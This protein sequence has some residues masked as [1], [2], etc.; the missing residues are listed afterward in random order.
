MDVLVLADAYPYPLQNGHALRLYHYIR[1]LQERH[2]FDLACTADTPVPP[3]L[4]ALF[5]RITVFPKPP[6]PAVSSWRRMRQAFSA[7]SLLRPSPEMGCMIAD[8]MKRPSYDLIW[9]AGDATLM[10]IPARRPIPLLGDLVDDGVLTVCRE[11]TR[12]RTLMGRLAKLRRA[13]LVAA[14]ER[15][16]YGKVDSCL[17]VSEIDERWFRR[18]CP[19]TPTRV[20]HNGVDAQF[21]RPMPGPEAPCSLVFEGNLAFK[22]NHDAVLYFCREILPLI[23]AKVPEATLTVVGKDPDAEI[24]DMAGQCITVTGYVDDIRPYLA[25]SA[26]F[27]CPMRKGAGIKNKILQAWAMG[28]ATVATPASTGGLDAQEGTN[29][30]IRDGTASFA[31][32]VV[33]L[34]RDPW[35]RRSLG[36][37]ARETILKHYTWEQKAGELD[38]LMQSLVTR[39]GARISYSRPRTDSSA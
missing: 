25:R 3:E 28:K 33:A 17:L 35:R 32:A 20:I 5:R 24:L 36:R 6:H 13:A 18:I 2:N 12:E 1:R 39:G 23:R 38:A 22:P 37:A 21:F 31:S 34:L 7:D 4:R 8:A 11:I 26:V 19:R 14:Y 15:R 10:T 27:V 16:H 9:A 29:I 30:Y